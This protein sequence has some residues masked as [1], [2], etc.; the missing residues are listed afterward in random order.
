MTG[1]LAESGLHIHLSIADAQGCVFGGHLMDQNLIFTTCELVIL[2]LPNVEFKREL[3][4]ATTFDELKIY[5]TN[6]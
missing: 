5:L 6:S 3:D 1:T 4:P 2:E